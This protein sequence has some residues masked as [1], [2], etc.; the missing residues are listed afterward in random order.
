MHKHCNVFARWTERNAG[1]S[2]ESCI[3]TISSK[4]RAEFKDQTKRKHMNHPVLVKWPSMVLYLFAA[5]VAASFAHAADNALCA[6]VKIQV[7]QELTLERQAFDARMRINNGLANVSLENVEVQVRFTDAAGNAVAA[8]SDPG[9][10]NALFFIRLDTMSNIDNVSGSGTVAPSSAADIHWL[11]IPAPGASNG[12]PQGT[13]YYVGARLSYTIGG[14]KQVTDVSPDY[15]FVKPMPQLT[16]DYFLPGEVYGDDA[17]TA[18]IEPPIPFH[19]GVRVSN[20]GTGWARQVK[21]DSAQPRIRENDQGLL[22]NFLIQGSEVNGDAAESSLLVDFGD[23]A[24]QDAGTARWIMTCSV[25]GRFVEFTASYSHSN[26]LGGELTSLLEAVNPHILVHDVRVDLPGR[27]AIRDFLAQDDSVLRVYESDNVDSAVTDQSAMATLAP[28]SPQN[29]LDRYR[30]AAPPTAG[31]M[32]VRLADPF[33]G[34]KRIHT[35]VRSDGKPIAPENAWLSKSRDEDHQWQ[36]FIN[37]FDVNTPGE[38]TI[39][40]GESSAGPQPPVLQFI[41][42]RNVAEG[43]QVSFIVEASDPNGTVPRMSASPLPAGARYTDQENGTAVF[44]WTP[45]VGQAGSYT[46]QFV[47]SDGALQ[48]AQRASITVFSLSDSDCDGMDDQWELDH[49]GNLDRDGSGD[50]DGDGVSDLDEYRAG[51]DP[52]A[53]NVPTVPSIFLPADHSEVDGLQPELT[54][55][56]SS[57]PDGDTVVYDFELYAD[58][59]LTRLVFAA[60]DH[61]ESRETT[62]WHVP[63]PLEENTWYYWRVRAGDG[64]GYSEW[65]YASFFVNTANDP[66]GPIHISRPVDDSEVDLHTPLLEVTNSVDLDGD[67]LTYSFEVGQDE[68]LASLVAV[69]RDIAPGAGGTTSWSVMPPLEEDRRYFWRAVV[70]DEHGDTASSPVGSFFV[71]TGN[72]APHAPAILAPADGSEV[73]D[74]DQTLVATNA[75]DGENDPLSY[76]FELD[77]VSTFDSSD[78]QISEMIPGA[79]HETGWAVTQLA[80]NTRYYWRVRAND[81]AADGPWA[82]AEFFV[83][84]ANDAPT[85]PTVRNPSDGAWVE[86]LTPELALIAAMDADNDTI[87]YAYELYSDAVLTR[88]IAAHDA[89]AEQWVVDPALSDNTWYYWRA[90]AVDEHGAFSDWSSVHR[91][92]TDDN[93]INDAPQ[94]SFVAPAAHVTTAAGPIAIRWQDSDPDSSANIEIYWDRDGSGED[95]VLIV[96]GLPEDEDGDGDAYQWDTAGLAEGDYYLYAVISDEA[97]RMVSYAPAPITIDRTPPGI[98]MVVDA[99]HVSPV[100]AGTTVTFTGTVTNDP[101]PFEYRFSLKGPAT[102]GVYIVMQDYSPVNTWPWTVTEDDYCTNTI[103]VAFRRPGATYYSGYKT[104]P[105]EGKPVPATNVAVSKTHQSPVSPGTTIT[106]TAQ[107]EGGNGYYEYKF[108]LKG[109]STNNQI[110]DV[111]GYSTDNVWQ[112]TPSQ[113]DLC[114]NYVYVRVRSSGSCNNYEASASA[115]YLVRYDP[116]TVLNI[117][118]SPEGAAPAGTIIAFTGEAAGGTGQYQYEFLLLNPATNSYNTVQGYSGNNQWNW[119]PTSEDIGTRRIKICARNVGSCASAEVYKY[120]NYNVL[121]P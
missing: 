69:V 107:G 87:G 16:L 116:P 71:N 120:I 102:N 77:T 10:T 7:D 51:T 93:G 65:A 59:A 85:T 111:R 101:G 32:L 100:V 22:I 113:S 75:V 53:G 36:H 109:P 30:L 5:L 83:N 72:S 56:N 86:S 9:N 60:R 23:I 82:Q 26:E 37:L 34:T 76:R 2:L 98:A 35:V 29:S 14:T 89:A 54:I 19:L 106:F 47:A 17:F 57:D 99:S 112:W 52:P 21:I 38:Y 90:R 108:Q 4:K 43:R 62:A 95:G 118:Q 6:R 73:S 88:R 70:T 55:E 80:D 1:I 103:K 13:L 104:L 105:F 15:I 119:V 41:P 97:T 39:S 64:A 115:Y 40:F 42:N 31:F 66:P 50:Y 121:A 48:A 33:L 110:V 96:E 11:I 27:D 49:F 28:L 114:T 20:N 91:F 78:L 58:A 94:I 74:R 61:M 25:S 79:S 68:S 81:G 44:D 84:T 92:F 67:P 3:G 8:S 46:I 12:L 117:S 24:P 18:E 63:A 45:V